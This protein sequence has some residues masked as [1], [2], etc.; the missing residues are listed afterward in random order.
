MKVNTKKIKIE[1]KR[2]GWTLSTLAIK[3]GIPRQ[4]LYLVLQNETAQL[5]T[6]N[7]IG[8]ALALDPKDLL[9]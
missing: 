1:T 2:L 6:L 8:E 3:V 4:T 7:K 5:S 9:V